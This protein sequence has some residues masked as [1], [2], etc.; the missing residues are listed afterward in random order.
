MA[1]LAPTLLEKASGSKKEKKA[2]RDSLADDDDDNRDW[3]ADYKAL[4]KTTAADIKEFNALKEKFTV[5]VVTY[6]DKDKWKEACKVMEREV[7]EF[8][9]RS[10]RDPGNQFGMKLLV[11]LEELMTTHLH[12]LLMGKHKAY[13]ELKAK[14]IRTGLQAA[15]NAYIERV[16]DEG[17]FQITKPYPDFNY[18]VVKH[19]MLGVTLE[20]SQSRNFRL[21]KAPDEVLELEKKTSK[22]KLAK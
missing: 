4:K 15:S 11:E 16:R 13:C 10:L 9:S 6:E 18:S 7:E 22:L 2:K 17:G 19:L 14:E 12:R 20:I 1:D 21:G 8:V 3:R 5:P